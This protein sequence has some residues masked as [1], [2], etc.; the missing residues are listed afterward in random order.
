[1]NLADWANLSTVLAGVS[2]IVSAINY[3]WTSLTKKKEAMRIAII[4]RMIIKDWGQPGNI[5]YADIDTNNL[6]FE[7][8]EELIDEGVLIRSWIPGTPGYMWNSKRMQ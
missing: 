4:K 1:M 6:V 7:A 8:L 2:I 3:V 5:K